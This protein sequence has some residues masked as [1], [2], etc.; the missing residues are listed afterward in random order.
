MTEN[1]IPPAESPPEEAEEVGTGID[2]ADP[3][4]RDP[5]E[6]ETMPGLDPVVSPIPPE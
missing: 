6:D 5:D 1:D 3:L 4:K 2:F